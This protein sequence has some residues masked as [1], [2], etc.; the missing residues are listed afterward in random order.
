[1]RDNPLT[2]LNQARDLFWSIHHLMRLHTQYRAPQKRTMRIH[3]NAN[4]R[5]FVYCLE[6]AQI[7]CYALQDTMRIRLNYGQILIDSRQLE[8]SLQNALNQERDI[9]AALSM[10]DRSLWLDLRR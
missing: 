4:E 1:M 7:A 10:L 6:D 5:T 8:R 2:A 3:Y 9:L